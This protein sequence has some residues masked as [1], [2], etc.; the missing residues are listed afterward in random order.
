MA[1]PGIRP[2]IV[3]YVRHV[4]AQNL[5]IRERGLSLSGALHYVTDRLSGN[6]ACVLHARNN[7]TRYVNCGLD[8]HI[9]K[10]FFLSSHHD[11]ARGSFTLVLST[12]L[13]VSALVARLVFGA[14]QHLLLLSFFTRARSTTSFSTIC[15]RSPCHCWLL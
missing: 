4:S 6:N 3:G 13:T 2:S 11:F 14:T 7:S 8:N 15:P 10:K 5:S 9:L 12:A 1:L